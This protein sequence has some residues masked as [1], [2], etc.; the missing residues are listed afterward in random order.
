MTM[1]T[2]QR[3]IFIL[4]IT[5]F[6]G[7]SYQKKSDIVF[8][9][10]YWFNENGGAGEALRVGG[11]LDEGNSI[12]KFGNN[13]NL[14]NAIKV[15]VIVEKILCHGDTRGLAISFNNNEWIV[16]PESDSIPKPQWEYQHHF[17]PTF[18]AP[19]DH[20]VEGE[21][22]T[23]NMKVD[24]QHSWNWPQ[25]LING[26]H[27]RIYY[28]P[29]S[30]NYSAGNVE[31][32]KNNPDENNDIELVCNVITNSKNVAQ[33]DFIGYY[34]GINWEGDGVYTQ[35][36][37][38]YDH[39]EL[40]NHI[41]SVKS[42]PFEKKWNTEWIPDQNQDIKIRARIMNKEGI[43][44]LTEPIENIDL[45]SRKHRIELCKPY[46]V[47]K[48]WATRNET[49]GEKINI[50]GD[51]SQ[52]VEAIICWSSWSPCYMDG[53]FI[54]GEKVFQSEGPCYESYQHW[55]NIENL[56]VLQKGENLITTGRKQ[57]DENGNFIHGM[58]VNY[59]GIMMLIKYRK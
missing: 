24:S 29:M 38:T 59:P 33:V 57:K 53:V 20:F 46:D 8:K 22:N 21:N 42:R 15:E 26:V 56:S 49:T 19:L 40:N 44:Y 17:Y 32:T 43:I 6:I 39:G 4:I 12:I 45:N 36:H 9:E 11:K 47:S 54:N 18:E 7:C 1:K 13:L 2:I 14:E 10:Y 30:I 41:G 48:H 52:A 3:L 35:W 58:E 16:V 27:L 23:F 50:K 34:E 5:T 37:Y 31:V 28:D 55:I 25:N 51:P